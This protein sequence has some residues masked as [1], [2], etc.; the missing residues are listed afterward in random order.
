MKSSP[1]TID[2]AEKPWLPYSLAISF[3]VAVLVACMMFAG[4]N[5]ALSSKW[6][7]LTTMLLSGLVFSRLGLFAMVKDAHKG[8]GV[9]SLAVGAAL[10][11]LAPLIFQ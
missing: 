6:L 11:G 8:L 4:A 7:P 9:T 1:S 2:Q 10:V 5:L 3:G